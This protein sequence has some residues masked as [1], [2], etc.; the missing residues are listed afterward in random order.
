MTANTSGAAGGQVEYLEIL[1]IR[2]LDLYFLDLYF[3]AVYVGA[4]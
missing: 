4:G 3:Y 2:V 1:T